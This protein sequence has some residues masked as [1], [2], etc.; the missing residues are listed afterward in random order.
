[1]Q[2]RNHIIYSVASSDSRYST[3]RQVRAFFTQ[4]WADDVFCTTND[5]ASKFCAC[6]NDAGKRGRFQR[7]LCRFFCII[8]ISYRLYSRYRTKPC[9][10]PDTLHCGRRGFHCAK[11]FPRHRIAD[12]TCESPPIRASS[13]WPA[14]LLCA[15]FNRGNLRIHNITVANRVHAKLHHANR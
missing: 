12:I 8:A 7:I 1:L 3:S 4:H 5:F 2:V 15:L 13:I 9:C 10:L 11:R 14:Q 6:R